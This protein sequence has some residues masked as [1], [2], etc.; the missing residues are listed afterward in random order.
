MFLFGNEKY[1]F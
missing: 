1:C